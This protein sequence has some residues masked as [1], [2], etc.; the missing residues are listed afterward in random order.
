MPT[1]DNLVIGSSGYIGSHLR[2]KLDSSNSYFISSSSEF[3]AFLD[4]SKDKIFKRVFWVAGSQ[5]P[6]DQSRYP[7]ENHP[8]IVNLRKFFDACREHFERFVFLSSG[9]CIYGPGSGEF[10]EDSPKSPINPY[11]EL[12]L[13]SEDLIVRSVDNYAILRVANVFGLGQKPNHSQGVIAHWVNA[14]RSQ[15]T[16]KV[17]GKLDSY[18]DYIDIE[19]L[20]DAII[21]SADSRVIDVFNIGSGTK[22]ELSIIIEIFKEAIGNHLGIEYFGPRATDRAGYFLNS[23]KA[24]KVFG[25]QKPKNIISLLEQTIKRELAKNSL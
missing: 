14:I 16:I 6:A 2:S 23:N 18:R 12:K 10:F 7:L 17:F 22:V 25:W 19:S 13:M 1:Y 21:L 9:G 5:S 8:D 24:E 20:L 11:G 3:S 4:S 15:K